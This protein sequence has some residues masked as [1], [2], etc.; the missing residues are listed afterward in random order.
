MEIFARL[1]RNTLQRSVEE[2]V[3]YGTS[4]EFTISTNKYLHR[5]DTGFVPTTNRAADYIIVTRSSPLISCVSSKRP[6]VYRG[7]LFWKI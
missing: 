6:G 5:F 7:R 3:K 4:N 1:S 2:R